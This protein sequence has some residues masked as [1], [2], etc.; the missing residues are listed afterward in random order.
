MTTQTSKPRAPLEAAIAVARPVNPVTAWGGI[1]VPKVQQSTL[2]SERMTQ[3]LASAFARTIPL[4]GTGTLEIPCPQQSTVPS[5]RRAQAFEHPI[6]GL[7]AHGA[8]A[9]V[10]IA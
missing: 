1:V 9:P 3:P 2:P 5:L 8:P 7:P 4:I 10:V 6:F